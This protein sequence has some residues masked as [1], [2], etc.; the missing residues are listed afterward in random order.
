MKCTRFYLRKVFQSDSA[1][2]LSDLP[3]KS[4]SVFH[5]GV[6]DISMILEQSVLD[7]GT[8][9][10]PEY[11]AVPLESGNHRVLGSP[12]ICIKTII[13]YWHSDS[14]QFIGLYKE[15]VESK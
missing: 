3:V 7:D 1:R 6:S 10:G 5:S 2:P 15:K 11:V 4:S 13:K 8:S 9:D 12:V 14:R